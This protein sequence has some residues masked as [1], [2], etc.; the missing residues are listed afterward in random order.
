MLM[1]M[2]D[3]SSELL[4]LS[5]KEFS[6]EHIQGNAPILLTDAL[7]EWPAMGRWCPTTLRSLSGQRFVDVSVSHSGRWKYKPDGTALD[8]KTQYVIPNVSLEQAAKWITTSTPEGPKYYVS[9]ASIGQKLPEL[10][11]DL[12]FPSLPKSTLALW[13]GSG[14]TVTPLHFDASNNLFAQVYGCKTITLFSPEQAQRLYP[15][16]S[17]SK[18]MHLS[19][20]D[21]E[22]PDLTAFPLYNNAT[23]TSFTIRA[24]QMLFLPAFWWH[25]VRSEGVSISVSCWFLPHLNQW[26]GPYASRMLR[27]AFKRDR[28]AKLRA[29]LG[30]SCHSLLNSAEDLLKAKSPLSILAISAALDDFDAG[31]ATMPHGLRDVH[32]KMETATLVAKVLD[33]D[34]PKIPSDKVMYLLTKL[35][36][37][38]RAK[39]EVIPSGSSS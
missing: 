2:S 39:Y 4:H 6:D 18:F 32:V 24:G 21:V 26:C 27:L 13:F 5:C 12:R 14:S 9:Q 33:D 3:F 8:P 1:R 31:P 22:R 15:Y 38:V 10:L 30:L 36:S 11:T 16:P 34:D 17:N 23:R 29:D 25:H 28:W 35:Q 7:L 19:S 20:V 37:I